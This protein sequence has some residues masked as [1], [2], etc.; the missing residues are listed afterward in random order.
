MLHSDALQSASVGLPSGGSRLD[1]TES[2]NFEAILRF[3]RK[4][5]RLCLA[6]LFGGVLLGIGYA[7]VSAP[8]YTATAAVLPL[9]PKAR[10][11][12]DAIIQS[13]AAHSTFVETQVQ[14]FA[15]DEVVGRVVGVPTW[16]INQVRP[17]LRS[18]QAPQREPR[19]ATIVRVRRALS[20]FR[21]GM[22]DVLEI[23]FTSA[24][25]P[26][27]PTLPMLSS[28][29]TLRVAW[30]CRK[31]SAPKPPRISGNFWRNFATKLSRSCHREKWP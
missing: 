19:Y 5:Y 13:D 22:S 10:N 8:S 11:T 17:L 14:D 9:N 31:A 30:P 1:D 16:L 18:S 25:L 4:R 15:S 20:V 29:A 27:L 12:S 2:I 6:W 3:L 24:T 28:G 23:P 7:A 21:V 26:V